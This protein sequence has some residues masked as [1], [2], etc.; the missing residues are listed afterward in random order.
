MEVVLEHQ[1][2]AAQAAAASTPE[3]SGSESN[4]LPLIHAAKAGNQEAFRQLYLRHVQASYWLAHSIVRNAADAEDIVQDTFITCYKK[5][6]SIEIAGESLLPWL[7]VTTKYTALNR[8]RSNQRRREYANTDQLEHIPDA[9]E[10][11]EDLEYQEALAAISYE[12]EQLSELDQRIY[13]S[14]IVQEK[15][16]AEAAAEHG[17]STGSVRNRLMR[18]RNKIRAGLSDAPG[19]QV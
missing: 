18:I 7:L 3:P 11:G 16:Y 14:C 10:L 12:V 9:A 8:Y 13:H 15:S 2:N 1:Q 4:D 17:V 19:K 6:N 5:L